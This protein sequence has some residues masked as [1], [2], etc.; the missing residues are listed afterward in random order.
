MR[1]QKR[2]NDVRSQGALAPANLKSDGAGPTP[3]QQSASAMGVG[4]NLRAALTDVHTADMPV[5]KS[6][7]NH[8]MTDLVNGNGSIDPSLAF[9]KLVRQPLG[10]SADE[11]SVN[12][13]RQA[14]ITGA[15]ISARYGVTA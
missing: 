6:W 10:S 8:M 11:Q 1:M 15:V 9:V 12:P 14:E 3:A 5:A 4:D 2:L 7:V 13:H